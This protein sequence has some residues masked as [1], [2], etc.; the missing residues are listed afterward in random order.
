M[1]IKKRKD[2]IEK[3]LAGLNSERKSLL[4]ELAEIRSL[5]FKMPPRL[6]GQRTLKQTPTSPLEKIKLFLDLFRCREDVYPK[7]W[8]NKIKGTKGYSPVCKNEWMAGVCKKPATKCSRCP[9]RAFAPLDST[10]V[11]AHLEGKTTIGTYAIREDDTCTFLAADF[12]KTA[13]RD[14]VL[15]YK[16]AAFDL[17]IQVAVER[18]RSG[19]GAHAW[20]FFSHPIP[21]RLAR[22]LGTII[23]A[24]AA[25]ERY[26]LGV[27][28][29]D[30]F[31]PS[32]DFLPSGGF[33]NLIA[34]PLQKA[35]RKEGNTVFIDDEMI[36]FK[37]QWA[38]LSRIRRLTSDEVLAVLSKRIPE[39]STSFL[40]CSED[41]ALYEAEKAADISSDKIDSSFYSRKVRM[42]IGAQLEI[43]IQGL[44]SKLISGFKRTATFANPKFFE[45]QRLRFS[46]WKTPRYIFCGDLA[47]NH[48]ILPRGTIDACRELAKRAGARIFL[49]DSRVALK[50]MKL[51]FQGKL[52]KNQKKAVTELARYESGVLVAPPGAGKT[53]MACSL[54][55]KRKV[56]TLIL[57]HRKQL[58]DQ[59]KLMVQKFLTIDPKKVGTFGSDGKKITG[60]IDIAMLQSLVR[61]KKKNDLLSKYEQ[62]VV[63]ECHH[64]PAF[65][66]ESVIKI[67]PARYFL[68]LTATPFRKDGHQAII[69]MQCGPLR[70]NFSTTEGPRLFKRVVIRE[71]KFFMPPE[72]GPQPMIHEVWNRL[73]TDP[74]RLQLIAG[75]IKTALQTGRFPLIFSERKK[76]LR[77]L[78][79]TI[80]QHITGLNAK[81]F[82]F[83]G[84]MSG[85][86]RKRALEEIRKSLGTGVK[87]YILSTGSLIG[88]GFDLPQVDTLVLAMPISF[89]GRLIQYA[90]RLHRENSG[91]SEVLIFDYLDKSLPLTISMFRKRAVAYKKLGYRIEA[92]SML[93]TSNHTGQRQL[94][95]E[96]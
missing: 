19:Q 46:T 70:H 73:I 13:W 68:G 52:S 7:L 71:T 2:E 8:E 37:N 53:V 27:E 10:A 21:A 63:D 42:S 78:S 39:K 23:L 92:P 22:Q 74:D 25:S 15:A 93:N 82:L 56:R 80:Q 72:T 89:K 29:H 55:G 96:E 48:L 6:L 51:R 28:S 32:Q 17:G 84:D 88:E 5:D 40:S 43:D 79:E 61:L 69:Y 34:L 49:N 11:H 41:P 20:I 44:P 87:P 91:K 57:V 77:L 66:F 59:W 90:G 35:I 31:F 67:I 45:L 85:L 14:D 95:D 60:M 65:S 26:T 4:E 86:A 81:E 30:R 50:K 33:G 12:D 1:D 83:V 54:I 64:V 58:L 24:L 9:N 62:V 3:R 75:D 36:S 76:H 47:P 94:F 16:K 18:S 38:F